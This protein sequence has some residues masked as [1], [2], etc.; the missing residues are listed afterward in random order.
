MLKTP[1]DK[2]IDLMVISMTHRW[3]MNVTATQR[4]C[5][6]GVNVWISDNRCAKFSTIEQIGWNFDV[7]T[8]LFVWR[9]S[10]NFTQWKNHKFLL[11]QKGKKL[12]KS[13]YCNYCIIRDEVYFIWNGFRRSRKELNKWEQVKEMAWKEVEQQ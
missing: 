4:P 1:F 2:L 9:H 12:K 3:K 11:I 8:S 6:I 7:D 5:E 13:V 10:F